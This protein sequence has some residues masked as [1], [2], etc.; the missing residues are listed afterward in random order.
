MLLILVICVELFVFV[1]ISCLYI[2]MSGHVLPRLDK[3]QISYICLCPLD[4][5]ILYSY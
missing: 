2:K 3:L 4:I 5:E 1:H